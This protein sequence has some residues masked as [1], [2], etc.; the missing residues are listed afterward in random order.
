MTNAPQ[1][2]KKLNLGI[3]LFAYIEIFIGIITLVSI[4]FSLILGINTKPPTVLIFVLSTALISASLGIGILKLNRHALHM[5]VF[6]SCVIVL[7]KILIFTN[8]ISLN[9]ALETK[10]PQDFKNIISI[11]Y[12]TLVIFYFTRKSVKMRFGERRKVFG[13]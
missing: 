13:L 11:F 8:I 10:I 7:S 3:L 6:L 1:A 2:S 5:L 12:H 4:I 9:G